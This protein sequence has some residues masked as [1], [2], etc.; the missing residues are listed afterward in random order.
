VILIHVSEFWYVYLCGFLGSLV[1]NILYL[2]LDQQ[3]TLIG[4]ISV[5]F[6]VFY[7]C[8]LILLIPVSVR[9]LH[10][11]G[12]SGWWLLLVFTIIGG[13]V[14]LFVFCLDSQPE[15]NEYGSSPK[16]TSGGSSTTNMV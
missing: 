2:S 8:L 13:F 11:I 4:I 5:L 7:I 12:R 3:G 10:D 15:S 14:L 6:L 1:Y 16:Y 9:R